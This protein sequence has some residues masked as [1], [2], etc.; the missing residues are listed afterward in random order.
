MVSVGLSRDKR[1]Y[2]LN[3]S[4]GLALF[5]LRYRDTKK[6]VKHDALPFLFVYHALTMLIR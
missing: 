2:Y 4:Y 5:D 1:A 6:R 3:P